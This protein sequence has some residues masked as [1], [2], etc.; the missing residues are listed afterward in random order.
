MYQDSEKY[1]ER[2]LVEH[3]QKVGGACLKFT[4]SHFTGL[5]DRIC[6]LPGGRVVFIELKSRGSGLSPR[7]KIVRKM[8]ENLGFAYYKID[9]HLQIEKVCWKESTCTDTKTEQQD[10]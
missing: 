8:L 4:S 2:K 1:T 7:Q 9:H 6:L 3:V 5:P 10:M